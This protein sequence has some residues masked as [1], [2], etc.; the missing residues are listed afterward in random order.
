MEMRDSHWHQRVHD[1]RKYADTTRLTRRDTGFRSQCHFGWDGIRHK[2]VA[3]TTVC[4]YRLQ[5]RL[6]VA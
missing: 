1:M 3:D 2:K 4:I 6:G 5:H